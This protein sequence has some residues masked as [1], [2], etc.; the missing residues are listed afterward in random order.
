MIPM[1]TAPGSSIRPDS[2]GVNSR[3]FCMNS[4]SS[5]SAPINETITV[6]EMMIASVNILNLNTL[7]SSIGVSRIS[8]HQTNN[9]ITNIPED[10][11]VRTTELVHPSYEAILK[12]Y[13]NEPKPTEDNTMDIISILG[14]LRSVTL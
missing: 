1:T 6:I 8:C 11:L 5:V 2:S 4:G 12:P 14:F 9:P 10:K 3:T 13:K 7:N